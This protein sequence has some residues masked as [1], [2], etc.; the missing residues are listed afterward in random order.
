MSIYERFKLTWYS[1][2]YSIFHNMGS[3]N[4][5]VAKL[6]NRYIYNLLKIKGKNIQENHG[7][8]SDVSN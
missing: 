3:S 6:N 5:N 4:E 1:E 2:L 7:L 8:T